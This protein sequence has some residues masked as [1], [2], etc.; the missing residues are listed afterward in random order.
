LGNWSI[1]Y[2]PTTDLEQQNIQLPEVTVR[3]NGE[4]YFH[5][6]GKEFGNL[7][8]TGAYFSPGLGTAMF[9]YDTYKKAEEGDWGGAALNTAFMALP[10]V[11][12]GVG[13]AAKGLS[14]TNLG[15]AY[16]VSRALNKEVKAFNGTV[17]DNYFKSPDSWYRVTESPEV[18]GIRE[19]GKNVTTRDMEVYPSRISNWRDS[20]LEND[21][22]IRLNTASEEP[23]L[24]IKPKSLS[25][26]KS[27][28]A[29]G[30]RSQ[31][32]AFKPWGGTFARS[33]FFPGYIME[34]ELPSVV[35]AGV[36]M[37]RTDFK[38][39]AI[40]DLVSGQRIG[41]KTGEMPITNL[42]AF[43]ELPNDLYSYEGEILPN[44]EISCSPSTQQLSGRTSLKFYERPSKLTE[45]ERAGLPKSDIQRQLNSS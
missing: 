10:Y 33:R 38:P 23:G 25:L 1:Y 16:N 7:V 13:L 2:D 27:G 21:R 9:G 17:G 39:T 28:A 29:H 5:E 18:E 31:A 11:G 3:P 22:V 36:G 12:K 15:R 8:K 42:R 37:S 20:F 6:A 40:E 43:R 32:A 4:N 30:N 26:V 44:K 34:G 19:L 41:F 14:R 45:A 24:Y 35:D